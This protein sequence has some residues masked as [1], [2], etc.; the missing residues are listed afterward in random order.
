MDDREQLRAEAHRLGRESEQAW[1]K[2][3]E[4]YKEPGYETA[5]AAAKR[6]DERFNSVVER[7]DG[8]KGS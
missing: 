6:V 7:L 2:A 4:K 8:G 5:V 1:A 3:A